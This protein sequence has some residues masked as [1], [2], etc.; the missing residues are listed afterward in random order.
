MTESSMLEM[1]PRTSDF[2]SL[3]NDERNEKQACFLE[4][5]IAEISIT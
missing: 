5:G 2:I 1:L 3:W 4:L